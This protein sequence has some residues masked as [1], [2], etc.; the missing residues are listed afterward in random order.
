MFWLSENLYQFGNNSLIIVGTGNPVT[1]A[2]FPIMVNFVAYSQH[3]G[4]LWTVEEMKTNSL[5]LFWIQFIHNAKLS[6]NLVKIHP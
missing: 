5:K 3:V 4:H 6:Q 2:G 1:T